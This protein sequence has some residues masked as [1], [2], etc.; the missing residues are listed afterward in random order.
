MA[1]LPRGASVFLHTLVNMRL[2]A[3]VVVVV[4]LLVGPVSPA[5]GRLP[6]EP[7][8]GPATAKAPW[9]AVGATSAPGSPATDDRP[10]H[11]EARRFWVEDRHRYTSPWY[12]GARR[13]MIGFGCTRAPYYAPAPRCSDR[14]GFHHGLDVAMPCGTKLFAGFRGRVV[15]PHSAGA[16]GPAYGAKAFRVR[17]PARGVDVVIGHVKRVYVEPG[18]RVRRGQ[19]VARANKLGAPDGCHLH[20]ETRPVRGGYASAVRPH[21]YLDLRR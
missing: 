4:G 17:N 18:E 7:V 13:K 8:P 14:R 16:L 6:A 1:C 11:R 2:T 21:P 12:A 3:A 10:R 15:R 20:F 9:A 19:L 5:G